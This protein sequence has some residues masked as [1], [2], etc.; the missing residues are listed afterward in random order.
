MEWVTLKRCRRHWWGICSAMRTFGW[1]LNAMSLMDIHCL[2]A[3]VSKKF[4]PKISFIY[5][6]FRIT[7]PTNRFI[8]KREPTT[9]MKMKKRPQPGALFLIGA[10]SAP[11][12]SI[13]QNITS[14]HPSVVLISKSNKIAFNVLS[15]LASLYNHSP[16]WAKHPAWF[17]TDTTGFT[18][19]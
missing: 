10:L 1:N 5:S 16:P 13:P 14:T 7:T 17:L 4:F 18:K 9:N 6:N 3:F 12:A 8:R 11:V 19:C 15:K 2:W